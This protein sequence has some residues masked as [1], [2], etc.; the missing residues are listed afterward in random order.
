MQRDK[1]LKRQEFLAKKRKRI[2]EQKAAA[3]AAGPAE[4][5]WEDSTLH[6]KLDEFA[7]IYDSLEEV[8]ENKEQIEGG[9]YF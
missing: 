1:L 8:F 7:T 5:T 9:C 2:Q 3:Q 6:E 4:D